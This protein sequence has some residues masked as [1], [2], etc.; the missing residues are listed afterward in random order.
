[1]TSRWD[2]LRSLRRR[3]PVGVQALVAIGLASVVLVLGLAAFAD[4]PG[5]SVFSDEEELAYCSPD[6]SEVRAPAEPP[7][8][9][10][11]WQGEPSLPTSLAE[12]RAATVGD[13]IFVGTGAELGDN[14]LVSVDRLYAYDPRTGRSEEHAP[15]PEPL[16]H[17]QFVSFGGDLYLVGGYSNGPGTNGLWRYSPD[18]RK[19][20][21]LEGMRLPRGGHG[22]AVIGDRLYVVGGT[23]DFALDQ[24]EAPTKSMEVYDF[25]TGEWSEAPG[26]PTA[27]HHFGVAALDGKLYAVGG[28][29]IGDL[30]LDSVER[31]D[32]AT[33]R[34]ET[35]PPLPQGSS[36]LTVAAAG[37]EIYA[38]AGAD[39]RDVDGWVTP[40][41]WAFNPERGQW[42][43]A[44]D[45]EV[46]RSDQAQAMFDGRIYILGG[47]PC[48]G[49]GRTDS[50]ESLSS[51]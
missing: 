23:V 17:S 50:V 1:M 18:E 38:I 11:T 42:R 39:N 40:A 43:R 8:G 9:P 47:A 25:S 36:G 3:V 28:R 13:R 24:T 2:N 32:P 14:E 30:A 19:W 46:P 21:E 6:D 45:I 41:T 15:T 7:P 48:V 29:E 34:W 27:R 22:A 10:G 33:G 20:T 5:P 35:L 44:A 16:H 49:F 4:L 37:G 31:F 51:L 12:V 26:M